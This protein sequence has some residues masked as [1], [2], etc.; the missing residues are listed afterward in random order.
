MYREYLCTD[1]HKDITGRDA[2]DLL[3]ALFCDVKGPI[4]PAAGD[5]RYFMVIVD[6]SGRLLRVFC[7]STRN[8]FFPRLLTF[9]IEMRRKFPDKRVKRI[10]ADNAGEF[11]SQIFTSYCS[12]Q[13][14]DLELPVEYTPQQNGM[15][16][17]HIK[18]VT[19]TARTILLQSNLPG[20]AWNYA[21]MHAQDLLN[22][23]PVS[24]STVSPMQQILGRPPAVDHLRAFGCTVYVPLPP[25]ARTDFGPQRRLGIYVGYDSPSIILYLDPLN[26]QLFRARFADCVFDESKYPRLGYNQDIPLTP[27]ERSSFL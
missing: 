18:R 5:Y 24:K 7:L 16:E 3:E 6:G 11:V 17:A 20:T 23:R 15:A 26:G 19:Y 22:L 10:R 27:K 1:P 4:N 8:L 13:G 12:A 9:L 25:P 21:V 14:I 2:L